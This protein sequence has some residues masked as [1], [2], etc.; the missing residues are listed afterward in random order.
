[1]EA[2]AITSDQVDEIIKKHEIIIASRSEGKFWKQLKYCPFTGTYTF[3]ASNGGKTST[4]YQHEA[5]D[6]Y[7][8]FRLREMSHGS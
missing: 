5:L 6:F 7:N 3:T 2:D 4:S 8:N 1:M